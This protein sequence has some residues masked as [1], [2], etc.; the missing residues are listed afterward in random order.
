[1]TFSNYLKGQLTDF[2]ENYRLYFWRTLGT[3]LTY[4]VF[5][6]IGIA[7]LLKFSVFNEALRSKQ[8]SLLSYLFGRY[9]LNQTYSMVDMSKS[10]LLFF[11]SLFSLGLLR[12][13]Q[14]E[15]DKVEELTF[16]SALKKLNMRDIISLLGILIVCV[17]VDFGLFRLE[18]FAN[19]GIK[20]YQFEKWI[21]ALLFQLRIYIPLI[22]FSLTLY[23]LTSPKRLRLTF[24]KM[25]FLYVSLWLANEFAYEIFIFTR[26]HI[27]NL[28]I[29]PFDESKI[30]LYESVLGILLVGFYFIVYHSAMTTSLKQLDHE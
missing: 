30:F 26:A 8:I 2:V 25:I 6:F 4:T 12:L 5:C 24:K 16:M 18:T 9:S 19:S 11:I 14:Q 22:L 15:S 10:L 7:L 29:S 13:E 21:D 20:N 3:V 23:N 27:F 17:P 1:M 28:L